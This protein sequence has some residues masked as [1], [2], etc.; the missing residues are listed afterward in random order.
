MQFF[1]EPSAKSQIAILQIRTIFMAE[2]HYSSNF[3]STEKMTFNF[4]GMT[5]N[6][7]HLLYGDKIGNICGNI[8]VFNSKNNN[9][10]IINS[11]FA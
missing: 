6:A 5:T 11:K 3:C 7:S 2:G 10:K 9:N 1:I 8:D 4:T